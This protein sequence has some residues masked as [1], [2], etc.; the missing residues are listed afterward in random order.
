M[1]SAFHCAIEKMKNAWCGRHGLVIND[2]K[3][4]KNIHGTV[5]RISPEAP[6]PVI[7][8]SRVI[9]CPGR[10]ANVRR[11]LPVSVRMP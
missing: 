6:V 11:I 7:R 1:N 2:V 4:D 8:R 5:E 10:A 3:R 9:H